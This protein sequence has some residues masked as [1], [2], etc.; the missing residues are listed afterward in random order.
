MATTT[1]FR[2]PGSNVPRDGGAPVVVP[3]SRLAGHL[4]S[5]A[6]RW[7]HGGLQVMSP[8]IIGGRRAVLAASRQTIEQ[9]VIR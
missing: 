6:Q 8:Q 4:A 3:V 2:N 1:D 5:L 7:N 9:A